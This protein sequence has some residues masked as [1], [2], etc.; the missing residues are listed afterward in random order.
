MRFPLFIELEGRSVIV[1]GGGAIGTR[2]ACAM[3]EYGAEVTVIAP[4][5]SEPL[6]EMA[7]N[8]QIFWKQ[9]QA[10]AR[11]LEGAFLVVTA[12]YD[13][14]VNHQ[15][16]IWCRSGGF[17]SMRQTGRKNVIFIFRGWPEKR[18]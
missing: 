15:A 2:R 7:E 9:K 6:R 8:G 17:R 13:R 14:D 5:I 4:E 18:K 10:E 16:V 3:A 1:I 12:V 11:D